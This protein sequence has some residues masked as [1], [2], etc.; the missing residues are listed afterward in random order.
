MTQIYF[1]VTDIVHFATRYNRVT[2]IQRVQLNIVTLLAHRHA[3]L[4]RCCFYDR[5]KQAFFEFDPSRRPK[6]FEFDAERFLVDIGLQKPARRFPSKVQIKTY[7]R[8]YNHNKA[9]RIWKKLDVYCSSLFAPRR[10]AGFGLTIRDGAS[11][12]RAIAPVSP[13]LHLSKRSILVSL[14][15][16]WLAPPSVWRFVQQHR[17]RGGE[18]VQMVYDII[19]ILHPEFYAPAEPPAFTAWLNSALH[20]AS[21]FICIS[22]WTADDLLKYAA[23]RSSTPVA[24]PIPLA[25]EII[26]FERNASVETPAQFSSFAVAK[27]VLCVGT[28][29]TRKN[30]VE[31]LEVWRQLLDELGD[32]MPL[33]VFAG[34]FGKGGKEFQEKLAMD[35]RL[36]AFVRV[37]HSPSDR[38]LAWLYKNS[39][40]STYVSRIEGWGL[41]VGESAWFGKLC[42]AS[43]ATSVPEVCGELADYVDPFDIASIKAGIKKPIVDAAHLRRREAQIA[44]APLRKWSDVADDIYRFVVGDG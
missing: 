11:L 34:K 42:V 12:P 38:E 17:D 8:R 21:R 2:G 14:G 3:G 28:I 19:P 25:H 39:L 4:I 23:T 40:Y 41:P 15:A 43:N 44:A 33:L 35:A 22:Q 24:R 32:A 10:L 13:L 30:G 31:L 16:L 36:S 7:L 9:L 18:V 5:K 29:E 20:Y 6:E 27:Y 1:D 26:G 37:I